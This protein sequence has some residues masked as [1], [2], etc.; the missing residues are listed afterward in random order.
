MR[1]EAWAALHLGSTKRIAAQE[2]PLTGWALEQRCFDLHFTDVQIHAYIAQNST[3]EEEKFD[4]FANY[5]SINMIS[6]KCEVNINLYRTFAMQLLIFTLHY[7]Q[8][9]CLL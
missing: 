5:S 2:I 6:F 8:F 7:V 4:S 9:H 3:Y 1:N